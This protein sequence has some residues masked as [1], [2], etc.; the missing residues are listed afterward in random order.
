MNDNNDDFRGMREELASGYAA[1]AAI[2]RAAAELLPRGDSRAAAHRRY[3]EMVDAMR[4]GLD[5]S[6][7]IRREALN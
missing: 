5:S 3:A 4:G 7:T 2:H 6:F 1:L